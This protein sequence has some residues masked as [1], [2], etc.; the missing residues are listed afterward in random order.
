MAGHGHGHAHGHGH[1]PQPI[2]EVVFSVLDE[3]VI[4]FTVPEKVLQSYG[5]NDGTEWIAKEGAGEGMEDS[6]RYMRWLQPMESDLA[7][8]VEYDMDEQDQV[9][10]D[11]VNNERRKDGKVPVSYEMFEVIFDKLEKEWFDLVKRI[12]KKASAFPAEDSSCAI[13]DDGE[14]EN[15]NAIVFCDGCNLAV[16]QDCYG[17]PYIPEGQWLCRKCT[18]SPDKPVNCVLCPNSYGAFK[19][20]T[21][22]QWAH[23][24]CAIWVPDT[25]VSNTVYMEPIDGVE[26]ISKNRWKLVCYLC[27]KRVGACIQCANRNCFTAFHVTCA[28]E[29]GLELKMKQGTER[30]ELR[31]YCERHSEN[32]VPA[33]G[34]PAPNGNKKKK[35]VTLLSLKRSATGQPL[36]L[37]HTASSKSARAYKKTY[38]SG[39]PIVPA[40]VFD[41]VLAYAARLKLTNK[42]EF[43]SLVCRYWSL[44]REA[45]RGAPLLKR[46]HLEPWT[47]SATSHQQ[48]DVEKAKKLE[49]IRLLRNDLENVRML[50]DR[51]RKR[52]KK[53]LERVQLFKSLMDDYVFPKDRIMKSVLDRIAAL[54]KQNMFAAPVSRLHVPDYYDIIKHPM[55]WSTMYEKLDRHEYLT[56]Q[57]FQD[58]VELVINNARRYNK[59][60]TPFHRM[61]VKVHEG[62]EPILAELEVLDSSDSTASKFAS[63]VSGLLT[64]EMVDSLFDYHFEQPSPSPSPP[65]EPLRLIAVKNGK[66]GKGKAKA[67]DAEEEPVGLGLDVGEPAQEGEAKALEG[68]S[69]PAPEEE[70]VLDVGETPVVKVKKRN[71]ELD[72]LHDSLSVEV[73]GGRGTPRARRGG[74]SAPEETPNAARLKQSEAVKGKKVDAVP[75]IEV[76]MEDEEGE[77]EKDVAMV[78]DGADVAEDKSKKGKRGKSKSKGKEKETKEAVEAEEKETKA[79]EKLKPVPKM[80]AELSPKEMFN[81]FETGH[82]LPEGSSRRRSIAPVTSTSAPAP[83]KSVHSPE[84]AA[85]APAPAAS[86]ELAEVPAP[87]PA[88][89]R[90]RRSASSAT[91]SSTR[92][93]TPR[94]DSA[95]PVLAANADAPVAST[96]T[97]RASRSA[98]AAEASKA[99]APTPKSA[100]KGKAAPAEAVS[101]PAKDSSTKTP[102][103]KK[104]KEKAAPAAADVDVE[105]A[106]KEAVAEK[107]GDEKINGVAANVKSER[108]QWTKRWDELQGTYKVTKKS[109]VPDGTLVWAKNPGYPAWPA[110]IADPKDPNSPERVVKAKPAGND[111]VMVLFFDETGTGSW[112]LPKDLYLLGE[113]TEFDQLCLSPFAILKSKKGKPTKNLKGTVASMTSGYQRAVA[114]MDVE[115]DGAGEGGAAES[116]GKKRKSSRKKN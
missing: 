73:T 36:S 89:S 25:G 77:V 9:W 52:E 28:R 60:D 80:L 44:K 3:L 105:E 78:V 56:T 109:Q 8:Q 5:F 45:R 62:A 88:A 74:A 40:Y 68:E 57:D 86:P 95:A 47:A 37:K 102:K 31:A 93:S 34:S 70:I 2:P 20:T 4:P 30:G 39:P 69:A 64:K 38:T 58:D 67:T 92:S 27:K 42:K 111:H 108:E 82:I 49:L 91:P 84:L 54:D 87:P 116:S 33:E 16:H 94:K 101:S 72:F 26:N 19:Q 43:V 12:P 18:V 97:S 1:S 110:E 35:S 113:S 100:K 29:R 23:L 103:S 51:V 71:R 53:K 50:T 114:N 76:E 79:V 7:K 66:K 22:A 21:T 98:A 81:S 6:G 14:C 104:G 48:T 90:A 115:V 85:P 55:D 32:F 106:E 75:E 11:N 65:K 10:L 59:K 112:L 41:K 24:V 17:V 96:S 61:A 13:C 107:E 83:K 99:D 15:S 46:L 63:E